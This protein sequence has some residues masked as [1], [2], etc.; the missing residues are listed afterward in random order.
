MIVRVG[1]L[2]RAEGRSSELGAAV[3]DDLVGVHVCGCAGAG[4]IDIHGEMGVML[5]LRYFPRRPGNQI[6]Q[7][8][9][10]G[11]EFLIGAGGCLFDQ[12]VCVDH[13]WIHGIAGNREIL[14]GPL[15]GGPVERG[16]RHL[17]LTHGIVLKT[18]FRHPPQDRQ[19][20]CCATWKKPCKVFRRNIRRS[21]VSYRHDE[22]T[23]AGLV[24]C[25]SGASLLRTRKRY[26][27]KREKSRQGT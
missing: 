17:Q 18:F 2:A 22:K 12:P 25:I 6:R 7:P 1:R 26:G 9:G 20:S 14:D 10:E 27:S 8:A 23:P 3:G 24:P 16:R 19:P 11:A 13:G 5:P 4:L 21:R 15:G